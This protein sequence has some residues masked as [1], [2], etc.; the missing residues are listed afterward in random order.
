[1]E[2]TSMKNLSK[3]GTGLKPMAQLMILSNDQLI[4]NKQMGAEKS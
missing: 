1:M 2:I 4:L 3:F